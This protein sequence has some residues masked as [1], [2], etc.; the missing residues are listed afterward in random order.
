MALM[1]SP[2]QPTIARQRTLVLEVKGV[3]KRYEIYDRPEDRLKQAI[4]PRL[5]RV[6]PRHFRRREPYFREFWALRDVSLELE[7]GDALGIL[8]R[9]GAGKST[10][11][12]IIA[13]TLTPTAGIAACRGKVAAL[14]ELGSGFA[15]DFTGRENA[16]M[17]ASLLGLSSVEIDAKF[18]QIEEF[19]EIGEFIDQPIKTYSSGMLVRLAFAVQTAVDPE[20]LIIDEALAV[21]DA[22]FQKKC[23][24]R[25]EELKNRGTSI[26]LVTHDSGTVVQFCNRALILEKGRVFAHGE[27][28]LIAR[29][30]HKLLF[31]KP[32]E[33]PTAEAGAAAAPA[34]SATGG[35]S[36]EVR[37]G[38]GEAVI[39]SVGLRNRHGRETAVV[40][41]HEAC[42][43]HFRA[44]FQTPVANKVAYGFIIC[45]SRG[46]EVYGTKSEFFSSYIEHAEPHSH[47]E[48]RL[49]FVARLVPGRYFLSAAL[50]HEG[51][52]AQPG[53]LDYRFDSLEF[54]VVGPSR[55]FS[56]SL[57]DL[58]AELSYVP[59]PR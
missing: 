21:G 34:A 53:F 38:S 48:C 46:V 36:R 1:L 40:Q 6:V 18:G 5:Q 51:N 39:L 32:A 24:A 23:F 42:E 35:K 8:G 15:P 31:G 37:Y 29:E 56:T 16:R 54:Q 27:P 7:P 52:P 9:N 57:V 45:N 13:G 19:A 25:L 43:A 14:L 47:F 50:A 44:A 30:Y 26:L 3:S 55:T 59:L 12:Q 41:T 2:D 28:H 17:N 33:V 11:L 10:L 4:I 49:R 20:V 58:D 22:R